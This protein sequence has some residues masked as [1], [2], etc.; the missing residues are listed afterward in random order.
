MWSTFFRAIFWFGHVVDNVFHARNVEGLKLE[1]A[2]ILD[3]AIDAVRTQEST[4]V[5]NHQHTVGR[6]THITLETVDAAQ[7][8]FKGFF[9]I[10][11][12]CIFVNPSTELDV[13]LQTVRTHF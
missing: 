8:D 11:V 5:H 2:R 12:P 4:V 3:A 13:F 10:L 7:S 1:H 6:E 9:R